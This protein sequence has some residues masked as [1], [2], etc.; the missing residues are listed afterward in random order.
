MDIAKATPEWQPQFAVAYN[1]ENS[2]ART[3]FDNALAAAG[4]ARIAAGDFAAARAYADGDNRALF[5]YFLSQLEAAGLDSMRAVHIAQDWTRG[6]ARPQPGTPRYDSLLKRV[7]EETF[8]GERFGTRNALRAR[9]YHVEGQRT[10]AHAL[11]NGEIIVGGNGRMY[12]AFS[13]NRYFVEKNGGLYIVEA[14]L[15]GQ[16][17]VRTNNKRWEFTGSIRVDKNQNFD[18]Q[19]S[20]RL[21][22][23]VVVGAK[24]EHFF[25]IAFNSGFRPPT[26]EQQFVKLQRANS[27]VLGG[28][29]RAFEFYNFINNVYTPISFD[30]FTSAR[31]RG[32]PLSEAAGLLQKFELK[33]IQP[34]VARSLEAGY[35]NNISDK[36]ILDASAYFTL[37]KNIVSTTQVVGPPPDFK[38]SFTPIQADSGRFSAGEIFINIDK[39]IT[40]Y[41][42]AVRAVYNFSPHLSLITNY[43]YNNFI[44][45]NSVRRVIYTNF[46]TPKHLA[47]ANFVARN[48]AKHL[49]FSVVVNYTSNFFAILSQDALIEVPAYATLDAQI[50]Y[51][52]PALKSF[53]KVGGTNI[54][55]NRHVEALGGGTVGALVYLQLTFDEFLR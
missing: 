32:V 33:A 53:V 48:I 8:L 30:A 28:N 6:E 10:F 31:A 4:R 44:E 46:S 29:P 11:P 19:I 5:P 12:S 42:A 55:N 23:G 45:D 20:P 2:F 41:G 18:M 17:A 51:K 15:Y 22:V 49:G 9:I 35:R 14:G 36:F 50:S 21:S 34:E 52:I 40:T 38:G 24:R 27:I 47:R 25:R 3:I 43:G 26:L 7:S 37:N 1:T 54:L 13:D 39:T 16:G